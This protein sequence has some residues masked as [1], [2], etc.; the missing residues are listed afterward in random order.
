[1]NQATLEIAEYVAKYF[2]PCDLGFARKIQDHM[3]VE[4]GLDFS[5][6]SRREFKRAILMAH[7]AVSRGWE[8][9]S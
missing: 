9:S 3:A 4:Q 8:P 2:G 1:M 7:G 6:C 5:E